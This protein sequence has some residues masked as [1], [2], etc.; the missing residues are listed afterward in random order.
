[1]ADSEG[2]V[3]QGVHV[4]YEDRVGVIWAGLVSG[5]LNIT[6]ESSA[7]ESYQHDPEDP[8]SLAPGTV[9]SVQ[10]GPDG[11]LWVLTGQWGRGAPA[12]L[13]RF[14]RER[15]RFVH[16]TAPEGWDRVGALLIDRSGSFWLNVSGLGAFDPES[17]RFAGPLLDQPY[18]AMRRAM[19]EDRRGDLWIPTQ[20]GVI[21][22]DPSSS[23]GS[24]FAPGGEEDRL[25]RR[26]RGF[27]QRRVN[28]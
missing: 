5:L 2:R 17:G 26:R 6:P 4:L 22:F 18:A 20:G 10:E 19:H 7:I 14:D 27:C 28:R 21:R 16:F 9:L 11:T 3:S 1:M 8:G 15:G 13:N 12:T 25:S 23:L 24:F